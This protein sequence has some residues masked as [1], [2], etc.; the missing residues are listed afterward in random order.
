MK[1]IVKELLKVSNK[2]TSNILNRDEIIRFVTEVRNILFLGYNEVIDK[3]V[4]VY[5]ENKLIIIKEILNDILNKL[6][7]NNKEE[8]INSFLKEI[9]NLKSKLNGDITAFLTS[10]P[11]VV[12]E[13]EIIISYPGFY[14]ICLYRIANILAKLNVSSVPRIISEHAHS[15]TGIDIHPKASIANNF[16]IDHGTGVVIGETSTIGSNVKIYQGVTL[17]ALS[18][19]NIEELR[20]VKRHPTIED[21]VTIYSGA[22]ILGGQTVIGKSSVIGSNVFITKSVEA[23]SK[24]IFTNYEQLQKVKGI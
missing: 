19:S 16:F 1:D 23:F 7:I 13:A 2:C 11:A 14:A 15:K 20:N 21:D 17:G 6:E 22:S 24:I 3:D 9:P 4:E 10:D 18:L 5:I 12:N 8:I